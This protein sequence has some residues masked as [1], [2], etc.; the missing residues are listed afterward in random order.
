[1]KNRIAITMSVGIMISSLT[2]Q[3]MLKANVERGEKNIYFSSPSGVKEVCVVPLHYQDADYKKKDLKKEQELC[4]Y[5]FYPLSSADQ[6]DKKELVALSAKLN[7]TNPGINIFS[8]PEGSTQDS[9]AAAKGEV[10]DSSKIG[11]YKNSTSCSYAP[12]LLAYYHVSRI[13]G[14]IGRVPVAVLRTMDLQTHKQLAAEGVAS[15]KAGDIINQTWVSLSSSLKAGAAGAK[16]DLLITDDGLQSYGAFIVNPKKEEFYKELFTPGA[17]ASARAAAFRDRNAV[18]AMLKNQA[19]IDKIVSSKWATDNVQKLFAMRDASEFILLDHLL[20]QQDRFG[21]IAYLERVAY[22][23]KDAASSAL[24]L[25]LANDMDEFNTEKQGGQVVADKLPLTIKSMILKDND[26]GVAKSNIAKAAG[27]LKQV[28]HMNPA[29][30]KRLMRFQKTIQ[31][32]EK[33]FTNNLLFTN[34]DFRETVANV[35]DATQILK[36]NCQSG[37]LKLDLDV[38]SYLTNGTIQSASCDVQ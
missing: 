7:S 21:N 5:S 13:L 33:F 26:C 37:A 23:K 19:S 32:N 1:M 15:T 3:A 11:K 35:N 2:T 29:T 14:G 28:A 12:S 24:S 27:L 20:D 31:A 8:I 6:A 36:A 10:K 9:V 16:R 30:Y 18:F 17:D 22:V 38:E 4:S 34:A 25:E